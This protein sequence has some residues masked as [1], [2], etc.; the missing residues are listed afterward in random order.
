MNKKNKAREFSEKETFR[1]PLGNAIKREGKRTSYRSR[2][3]NIVST[4]CLFFL[5][6]LWNAQKA[7]DKTRVLLMYFLVQLPR[8]NLP[9]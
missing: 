4:V 1:K 2:V 9:S 5:V 6:Y 3:F 8:D 7:R